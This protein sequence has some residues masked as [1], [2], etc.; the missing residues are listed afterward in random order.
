MEVG[1]SET[2]QK[3]ETVGQFTPREHEHSLASGRVASHNASASP[4]RDTPDV[5]LGHHRHRPRRQHALARRNGVP[6]EVERVVCSKCAEVIV[7][8]PLRRAE[9]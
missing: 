9:A 7:E 3:R 2:H 8:R 1:V 5:L 6:Y 4:G